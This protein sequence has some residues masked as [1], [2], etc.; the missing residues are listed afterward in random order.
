MEVKGKVVSVDMDAVIQKNGGGTYNGA[1][2]SFR[3]MGTGKLVE[4]NFHANSLKYNP[5]LKNQLGNLKPN[6][7]FVMVKLKEGEFWNVKSILPEGATTVT[8]ESPANVGKS[9]SPAPAKSGGN[10]ETADERAAK[11]VYINRLSSI[12]SAINLLS[13]THK[14]APQAKGAKEA[15]V[16]DVVAIAKEFEKYVLTGSIGVDD[17]VS[18]SLDEDEDGAWDNV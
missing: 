8:D 10:W 3:D 12:S 14:S 18:D 1:Q 2:L 7:I 6:D 13:I 17:I 16:A 9:A 5:S 15:T 11:Q 4:Q